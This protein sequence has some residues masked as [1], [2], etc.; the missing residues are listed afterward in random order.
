MHCI[1][2]RI[3]AGLYAGLAKKGKRKINDMILFIMLF[4]RFIT[5]FYLEVIN[6]RD[7]LRGGKWLM[8]NSQDVLLRRE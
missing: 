2:G 6:K 8:D 4:R 5:M 3:Y 1:D 7:V